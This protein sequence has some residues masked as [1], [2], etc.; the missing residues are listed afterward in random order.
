MW[1]TRIQQLDR[2]FEAWSHYITGSFQLNHTLMQKSLDVSMWELLYNFNLC[3]KVNRF[4]Q[5]LKIIPSKKK[6]VELKT[7]QKTTKVKFLIRKA[8]VEDSML[9]IMHNF[10]TYR[11]IVFMI[12][13]VDGSGRWGWQLPALGSSSQGGGG[14][15]GWLTSLGCCNRQGSGPHLV[16]Y[17]Q[18]SDIAGAPGYLPCQESSFSHRL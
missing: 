15:G 3:W 12:R 1:E 16:P 10:S 18:R 8:K 9:S 5:F 2:E 7:K 4:L 13:V 6:I 14:R 17:R 11:V